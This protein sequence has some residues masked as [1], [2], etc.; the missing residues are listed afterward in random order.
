MGIQKFGNNQVIPPE[1]HN[2]FKI[3]PKKLK[4]CVGRKVRNLPI[5]LIIYAARNQY[6]H[7]DEKE[8]TE[9]INKRVFQLLSSYETGDKYTDPAFDINNPDLTI[10]SHNIVGLLG[11]ITY[12]NYLC[13]MRCMLS[14]P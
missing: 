12:E 10:Y 5:G 3:P 6:N 8:L 7:L 9:Q 2:I 4:F 13:D 11:W 14:I 1:L